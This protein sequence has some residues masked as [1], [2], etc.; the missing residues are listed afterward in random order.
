ME[1]YQVYDDCLLSGLEPHTVGYSRTCL[2]HLV[3]VNDVTQS[4]HSRG[5]YLLKIMDEC[6][7][8]T[9]AK[10][11]HMMA[12][13]ACLSATNFHKKVHKGRHMLFKSLNHYLFHH[14]TLLLKGDPSQ[15]SFYYPDNNLF[16]KMYDVSHI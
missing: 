14:L 6:A 10:H 8:I 15:V 11:C 16:S 2:S 5:G 13:T 7:G 3:G 4:G 12:V 9:A 1:I